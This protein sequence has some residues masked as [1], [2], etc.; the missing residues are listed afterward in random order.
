MRIALLLVALLPGVAAA[1]GDPAY[2]AELQQ[3]ARAAGLSAQPY[4]H[5]LL[6][7]QPNRIRS[8]VT[9][10]VDA[11]HFFLAADGKVDPQAE[12][13][14]TLA[15]FFSET[16]RHDEP[17]QCRVKGR[18]EWLKGKLRFDPA[19]LPEQPCEYYE[20][21][22]AAMDPGSISLVF[23]ANDLNSPAT[24][25]GHTLLRVDAQ[26]RDEPALLA[27]AIN[28]A[29]EV[30][31][32]DADVGYIVKA[33]VGG[34]YG[35]YST[36]RYHERVRQYVRVNHRDLWEYPVRL[37]REERWRVMWHLWEMRDVGSDYLF[38]TENCAYMLLSLLDTG[39]ETSTLTAEFDDPIPYVIPVDTIR[40]ARDAGVL[41]PPTLRPSMARTLSHRLG[42]LAPQQYDWVLDY[43]DG[44]AGFDDA[45]HA[46][47]SARD[48]ARMLEVAGDY[49]LFRQQ[50][51]NLVRELAMPR[52]R[53]ALT[54]RSA[55]PERSGF[56]PVPVPAVTPDHGHESSR[57][58]V[59]VRA[60]RE[61]T[62][63]VIRAR[64]AYHDRLDPT[65]GFLP[66]GEIEFVDLSLLVGDKVRV[67]ELKLVSVQTVAPW[68]RA[69]RPW[70]WQA[71][72]GLRRYGLDNIAARP[73]F[74]LGA[75]ADGGLGFAAGRNDVALAYLFAIASVD[76]N[77]D[78]E[79]GYALAGGGRAGLWLP[80]SNNFLQQLEVD[81][82]E[83][84][85][86]G[87][88]RLLLGKFS[89]QLQFTPRHGVRAIYSY[90]EQD[91]ADWR[92]AELRWQYYF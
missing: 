53:A 31:T 33:L 20:K 43:A 74:A 62:A 72:G 86:G 13:D 48:R 23:A 47:A 80:W 35:Q 36:Y 22:A 88:E 34:F 4:W 77:R 65:A 11:A 44:D 63:A 49:L 84:W 91:D 52:M 16:L 18:Y 6:H 64:G 71:Q 79:D 55:L 46:G 70:L 45:R 39:N 38:F 32:E 29:A 8:G 19:R 78:V 7:Y 58:A 25:Y 87:A 21:W 12:L 26:G 37:S 42:Q 3:A 81:A 51:G 2:L 90:G 67:G 73:Q 10:S 76:A 56:A 1:A 66:G 9:S 5:K 89:T 82:L 92:S 60:D 40:A 41:D 50:A 57:L 61:D 27:H 75:Y 68:D 15:S 28:Y 85:D 69:F 59:G 17:P 14:A 54:A 83:P 30:A 24:M